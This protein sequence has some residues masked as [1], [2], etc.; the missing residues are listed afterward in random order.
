MK[1]PFTFQ[2]IKERQSNRGVV[3]ESILRDSDTE[4]VT[5]KD[6][7]ELTV[8]REERVEDSRNENSS[9]AEEDESTPRV[10][11][12]RIQESIPGTHGGRSSKNQDLVD[13]RAGE[14]RRGSVISLARE[15]DGREDRYQ[16][17]TE[18]RQG[19][20]ATIKRS[21]G[22]EGY[23]DGG[24]ERRH[25]DETKHS[26]GRKDRSCNKEYR[27]SREADRLAAMESDYRSVDK[28][29]TSEIR[30]GRDV[31]LPDGISRSTS[32]DY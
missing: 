14:Q 23:I 2:R 1:E 29:I 16:N 8:R 30:R 18:I 9:K 11:D 7:R 6:I 26:D 19:R 12:D 22:D 20:R 17:D 15:V 3:R 4:S 32:A 27:Y 10:H 13:H 25:S 24:Y 31:F 28:C 21:D 5:R